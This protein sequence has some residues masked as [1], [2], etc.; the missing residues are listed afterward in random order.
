[1]E[2]RNIHTLDFEVVGILVPGVWVPLDAWPTATSRLLGMGSEGELHLL[3]KF[4]LKSKGFEV[5]G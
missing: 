4:P 3:T 5:E 1:M 2:D